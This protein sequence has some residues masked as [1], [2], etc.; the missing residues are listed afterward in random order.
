M[1]QPPVLALPNFQIP[2]VVECDASREAIGVVL[3]QQGRPIAFFSQALKGRTLFL[4]TYEKKFF[5]LVSAIQKW[6]PYLLGPAFGVKID[7]QSLKF[8]LKQWVGTPVQQKWISKL[9]GYDFVVEFK[10]GRDNVVADALSRYH[11]DIS[12]ALTMISVPS[13]DWLTEIRSLY[14]GDPKLTALW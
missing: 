6:R 5:A 3:M 1:T 2:F 12:V 10:K 7:H 14:E 13:W 8:L 4:S 9:M 11:G